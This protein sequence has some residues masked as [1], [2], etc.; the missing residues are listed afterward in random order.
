MS[1]QETVK[2]AR[3]LLVRSDLELDD[4][5]QA[6]VDASREAL[7]LNI[8]EEANTKEAVRTELIGY[9]PLQELLEDPSIEEIWINSPE[10]IYFARAGISGSIPI[11]LDQ[12]SLSVIVERM[13]RSSG[14]RLDRSTPFV[15]AS[16]PDGSRLHVVIP[17]ITRQFWSV[18]IRKFP[19]K[20]IQL[21]NLLEYG[22][23]SRFQFAYLRSS[24]LAKKNFLVSGATQSGK[25]TLLCALLNET[26]NSERLISVEETFEIRV[27]KSDWVAL[28]TRQPNLEGIGEVTLRRLIKEA[29][30]MRPDRLVVGEV[31]EAESLDLLIALNSGLP[32]ACTIHANSARDAIAKLGTLPLLAGQNISSAFILPAVGNCIDIVVH[33]RLNADG[34]RSVEEILEVSWNNAESV[35]EFKEIVDHELV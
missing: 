28:Q 8:A 19:P 11:H 3:H 26:A 1:V 25:T 5:I 14:R 15:D 20:V 24:V 2:L 4:A 22:N 32:G 9:G 21:S 16:L 27:E 10:R 34:S 31:R 23:I 18:N 35:I 30:R 12:K 29:L 6:A 7:P 13:L 33:C 17:E